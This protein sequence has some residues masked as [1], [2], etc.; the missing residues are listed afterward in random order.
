MVPSQ[1]D[2]YLPVIYLRKMYHPK[3]ENPSI[4][5]GCSTLDDSRYSATASFSII[6]FKCAV[7]SLCNFTGMVN[8]PKVFSGSCS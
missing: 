2:S 6:T 3:K 4:S 1:I 5:P 8:S 7:T